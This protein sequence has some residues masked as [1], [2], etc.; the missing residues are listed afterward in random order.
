MRVVGLIAFAATF[1]LSVATLRLM[2]LGPRRGEAPRQLAAQVN[3]PSPLLTAPSP[4]TPVPVRSPY[5]RPRGG[6]VGPPPLP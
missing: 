5:R 3:P 4:H 2:I 6:C 1:W